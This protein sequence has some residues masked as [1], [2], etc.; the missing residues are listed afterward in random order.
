MN[1]NDSVCSL[2]LYSGEKFE[3]AAKL[4]LVKSDVLD[5]FGGQEPQAF[6]S[7]D[8]RGLFP[9][10]LCHLKVPFSA[11]PHQSP[12]TNQSERSESDHSSQPALQW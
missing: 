9:S 2:A 5:S 10:R 12:Q 3:S 1:A 8:S 6:A 7:L 4:K 11:S